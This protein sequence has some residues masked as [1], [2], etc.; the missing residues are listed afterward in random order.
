[1][2]EPGDH[3]QLLLP[4]GDLLEVEQTADDFSINRSRGYV[5]CNHPTSKS[6]KDS[7]SEIPVTTG[8]W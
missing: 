3:F 5:V 7:D 8:R 1:M 2:V 6:A 4:D